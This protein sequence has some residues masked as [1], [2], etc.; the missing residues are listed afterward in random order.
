MIRIAI[1]EDIERIFNTLKNKI[2][3]SKDFQ[4]VDWSKTGK[5]ILHKMQKGLEADVILMDIEM[6][7][8]NGIEATTKIISNYP[9]TKIL[10]CSVYDDEQHLFEAIMAGAKGYILKDETP[11]KVHRSLFETLE[12]GSAMS[13]SMAL[14]ALNI[15]KNGKPVSAKEEENSSNL[16]KRELE[17]VEL[18]A[19]GLSYE[20]V[21]DT[22]GISYG[23]TRKHIENIYRKLNV[24]SK[25]DA[26]NK[27]KNNNF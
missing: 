14:K 23:T 12:G 9:Y 5:E 20:R 10:M 19:K 24:H 4:V 22:L 7:E 27:L 13:S 17:I 16:T 8:M 25:L 3:L 11:E 6:P 18:L 21:S 15:I 1:A 26:I 2:E